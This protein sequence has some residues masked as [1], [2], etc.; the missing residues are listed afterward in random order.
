MWQEL[1]AYYRLAEMLEEAC[2]P[3]S[4]ASR[5]TK[6][7][8]PFGRGDAGARI[9]AVADAF[10]ALTKWISNQV[11]AP[12]TI[13]STPGADF[14]PGVIQTTG[15]ELDVAV[16]HQLLGERRPPRQA[17]SAAARALVHDRALGE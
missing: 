15:R 12:T 2:A 7:T 17:E 3:D 14:S 10:D 9:V 4:W 6:L 11:G 16:H 1:H 13:D 5:A 8:N